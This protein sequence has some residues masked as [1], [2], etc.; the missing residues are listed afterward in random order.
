MSFN[1]LAPEAQVYSYLNNR[2]YGIDVKETQANGKVLANI[3][4]K[5][6]KG[7]YGFSFDLGFKATFSDTIK[8]SDLSATQA[9]T[10]SDRSS[11]SDN[12]DYHLGSKDIEL[13]TPAV[14]EA[15]KSKIEA[16]SISTTLPASFFEVD[17]EA[18]DSDITDEVVEHLVIDFES[19]I[20]DINL[21]DEDT[22]HGCVHILIDGNLNFITDFKATYDTEYKRASFS[23]GV[24]LSAKIN[25]ATNI[26]V[27][28]LEFSEFS[29]SDGEL[30]KNDCR[31]SV[32]DIILIKEL[33]S[34]EIAKTHENQKG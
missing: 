22:A 31:V 7:N 32:C 1:P 33:I 24:M 28:K 11:K 19:D 6:P 2:N 5:S 8:L 18:E 17:T 9:S 10:W 20:Y 21:T 34:K 29:K 3:T 16:D 30:T 14:I 15:I 26:K 4:H 12:I 25:K 27:G 23:N 13:L